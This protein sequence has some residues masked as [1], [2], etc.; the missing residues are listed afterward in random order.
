MIVF[1]SKQHEY[2]E[3]TH[4]EKGIDVDFLTTDNS[5]RYKQ[6]FFTILQCHLDNFH[7]FY[8]EEER[9]L[10]QITSHV[11]KC[12][13]RI[14]AKQEELEESHDRDDLK[15]IL[16]MEKEIRK[17]IANLKRFIA[18]SKERFI[19]SIKAFDEYHGSSVGEEEL[20]SLE[21]N[22]DFING[23]RL[24]QLVSLLDELKIKETLS[25][26]KMDD[27]VLCI[28]KS[29]SRKSSR[30]VK[31]SLRSR[32]SSICSVQERKYMSA[33][34]VN[35]YTVQSTQSRSNFSKMDSVSGQDESVSSSKSFA[36]NFFNKLSRKKK[37]IR[38]QATPTI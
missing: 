9:K 1:S 16:M 15:I 26:M 22:H 30:Q 35:N 24:N 6:T 5:L 25:F 17:S 23:K 21:E 29:R 32:N 19:I 34:D 13:K 2:G 20:E 27:G 12:F 33:A 14:M 11:K 38:R 4:K 8:H 36:K 7:Y 18:E 10:V 28:D 31:E 3:E 37:I